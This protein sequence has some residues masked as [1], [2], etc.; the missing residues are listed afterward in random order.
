MRSRLLDGLVRSLLLFL[1]SIVLVAGFYFHGE[2]YQIGLYPL[3]LLGGFV[4]F[5]VIGAARIILA[6]EIPR[7]RATGDLAFPLDE[8]DRVRRGAVE[9][10]VRPVDAA[11]PHVGQAVRARYETGAPFGRLVVVDASRTYLEDITDEQ[12]RL[13]GHA[14]AAALR[15]VGAARWRWRPGDVVAILRVRPEGGRA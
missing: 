11:L 2:F 12:A 14:S 8:G 10:V 7:G 1:L 15:E 4:T 13:A 5:L 6:G 3:L 9:L